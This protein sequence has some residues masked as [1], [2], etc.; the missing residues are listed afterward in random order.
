MG[1]KLLAG[2]GNTIGGRRQFNPAKVVFRCLMAVSS[3]T[4][5]ALASV[6]Y[7]AKGASLNNLTDL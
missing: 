2:C 3:V 7:S 1:D 5:F 6:E 4:L